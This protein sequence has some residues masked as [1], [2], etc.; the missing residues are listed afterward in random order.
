[1]NEYNP[2]VGDSYLVTNNRYYKDRIITIVAV[3][4]DRVYWDCEHKTS[5]SLAHIDGHRLNY[6]DAI[7]KLNFDS[8]ARKYGLVKGV[9][10]APTWEL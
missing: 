7:D 3:T 5:S 6:F 2:R 9:R 10:H 4:N 1:M 8:F